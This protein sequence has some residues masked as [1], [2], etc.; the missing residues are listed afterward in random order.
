MKSLTEWIGAA[1]LMP[2]MSVPLA[3][4]Q[5]HEAMALMREDS[6]FDAATAAHGI[7]GWVASF[8]PNGSML[9]D[10][11]APTTGTAAIRD[12]MAGFFA[13]SSASLR[14]KPTSGG[15]LLAGKVGYTIGTYERRRRNSA[16]VLMRATGRYTT[17]WMKQPDHSWKIILD[18][19]AA[20]GPPEEVR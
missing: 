6:L 12:A 9:S 18:T 4:Q 14:W 15:M 11:T 13:D 2:A 8:A 7:E 10:T 1:L 20:D 16:G 5:P 17:V 19:G 3:A